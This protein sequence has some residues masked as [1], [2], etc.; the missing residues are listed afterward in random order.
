MALW[1]RFARAIRLPRVL[2]GKFRSAFGNERSMIKAFETE[3][4]TN[5]VFARYS[6]SAP[7]N[8]A[9]I[10]VDITSASASAQPHDSV[11]R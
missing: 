4:Q 5:R 10:Q 11:E 1:V 9:N 7:H 6:N 8:K 2:G 3:A